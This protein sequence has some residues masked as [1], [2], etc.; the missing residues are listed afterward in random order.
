MSNFVF[1]FSAKNIF[2]HI[3][4]LVKVKF[5]NCVHAHMCSYFFHSASKVRHFHLSLS[6]FVLHLFSEWISVIQISWSRSAGK[7]PSLR[8]VLTFRY[9]FTS[10][11]FF[12]TIYKAE[13][14][15]KS[16]KSVNTPPTPSCSKTS[17]STLVSLQSSSHRHTL[18][19]SFFRVIWPISLF[20]TKE[21]VTL[22]T[23]SPARTLMM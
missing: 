1:I 11:P 10:S 2:I 13:H 18:T 6:I 3:Q 5:R 22:Y 20:P 4:C 14:S 9:P 19:W 12:T 7:K 8:P 21:R 17:I 23:L 16:E 15:Y